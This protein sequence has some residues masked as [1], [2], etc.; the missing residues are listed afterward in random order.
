MVDQGILSGLKV[1][2]LSQVIA[3]PYATKLLADYGA[4]VIKVENPAAGDPARRM[5]PFQGDDPH[6]EKSGL[7]LHLNT[8]KRGVTLNLKTQLGRKILLELVRSTDLLLES[9]RPGAM[10]SFGLGY[11][12][13]QEVNPQL[14]VVSVSNFGQTGP[15]RD[16]K[17]TEIVL[18]AMGGEMHACGI[19]GREPV[20]LFGDVGQFHAGLVTAGYAMGGIFAKDLQ[21]I[22]QHIDISLFE[23]WASSQDRRSTSILGAQY[24][25]GEPRH[26]TDPGGRGY[27][28]AGWY[29]TQDGLLKS[30]VSWNHIQAAV[31]FFDNPGWP[32][33]WMRDP[34]WV[35]QASTGNEEMRQQLDELLYP[36]MA[37]RTMIEA[38]RDTQKYRLPT[39]PYYT[40][41][42]LLKDPHFAEARKCFIEVDHPVAGKVTQPAPPYRFE[43]VGYKMRRPA[44]LL[45]QHNQEVYGELGYSKEDLVILR[46]LGVI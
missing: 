25:P 33:P 23:V 30:G 16:Y 41:A 2:D 11:E 3:G 8:N 46:G 32:H 42:D 13:L 35:D 34:K 14:V 43:G 18:Y 28:P 17:A 44:P 9:Y 6:P 21:G 4:A 26:P 24:A 39:S 15:Y 40:M 1:I 12:T 31:N 20:K 37:E 19:P 36:W 38:W 27:P 10:E 7:F 45:G 22:G 5:G 29:P